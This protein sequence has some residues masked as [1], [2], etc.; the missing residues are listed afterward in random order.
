MAHVEGIKSQ[1]GAAL[2]IFFL[3]NST[4]DRVEVTIKEQKRHDIVFGHFY[5]VL[6]TFL[7]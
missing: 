3:F 6:G 5:K 1:Q 7:I 2:K 4:I